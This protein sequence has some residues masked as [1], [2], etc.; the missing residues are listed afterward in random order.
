MVMQTL[1][2]YEKQ[3]KWV[4]VSN[5]LFDNENPRLPTGAKRWSQNE[6]LKVYEREFDLL[7]I[8]QSMADNGYF[9][10]E[11][12]IVIPKSKD[13]FIVVEGNRRLA[14]LKVLT[15]PELRR[16]TR[17][18][19]TWEKLAKHA[20]ALGHDLTLAPV[21][22]HK[23]RD[24]LIAILGFRHIT[25]ILK[26]D[27]LSKARFIN[28]LVEQRG[29]EADFSELARDIG[30]L[31]PTVRDNYVAYRLYIQAR[32]QF[33]ID[34][35]N[36]EKSFGVFYRALSSAPILDF[37]GLKKEESPVKLRS[38]ISKRKANALKEL[39]EYIHGTAEVEPVLTDSRQLT[40]LG[41]VLASPEAL[42]SL[43]V[44]KNLKRAYALT[45]GE[46]RSLME[47]LQR[48]DFL[49]GETLKDVYKHK[50]STKVAHWVERC[51]GRMFEIL[52]YFPEVETRLRRV[53]KKAEGRLVDRGAST[54]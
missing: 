45:G 13:T 32:D 25:G 48:A 38:P 28:L 10:E 9:V 3:L 33:D 37:I 39:I 50:Q 22:V 5:L 43:R 54:S 23:S 51:A 35:R 36:L 19:K 12:L 52:K 34:T 6:I 31:R 20:R 21:V 29:K 16:I 4:P 15:D 47:N 42:D 46:E 30:S 49:L 7:P 8:V 26:W 11:P 1:A 44:H 17:D 27:P 14:A 2:V 53:E 40:M 18:R 41:E 24:E